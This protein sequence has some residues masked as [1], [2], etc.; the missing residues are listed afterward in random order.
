MS[1]ITVL[2]ASGF[3]GSA[4]IRRLKKTGVG[5]FAPSKSE[6]LVNQSLGR[7]IYCIGLTA[8]FKS[9]PFETVEAHACYLGR[10]LRDCDIDSLVYL[11]SARV[12]RH[13]K[14]PARE[15]DLIPV[16]S[17]DRSDLYNIS[18]MMG[19]SLALA[20]GKNV[21]VA[22]LSNVYGEDFTSQNFLPTIIKE[23]ISNGRVTVHTAPEAEKDYVS[24]D[25]V[26]D[27][28]LK[29]A[30]GGAKQNIYNLASGKNLSNRA[31]LRKISEVTGCEVDFDATASDKG[32]P[33]ISIERISS[34]FGFRPRY[35]LDDLAELIDLY[36]QHYRKPG[37]GSPDRRQF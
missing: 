20:S 5:Y 32:F 6:S 29:I 1:P 7:V 36:Q 24:I 21:R 15:E 26:V 27:G 23:A 9:R 14:A 18:K 37:T 31:L 12:Y 10:I 34:E 22:R 2:G 16:T 11:S 4:L 35:L 33:E 28:L 8:D 17:S 3:I 19:E 13:Q 30:V 25:D